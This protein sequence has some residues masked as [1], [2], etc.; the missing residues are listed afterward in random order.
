MVS[1]PVFPYIRIAGAPVRNEVRQKHPELTHHS[2]RIIAM[3][4]SYI[5]LYVIMTGI[6]IPSVAQTEIFKKKTHQAKD[7]IALN[8]RFLEPAGFDSAAP[9]TQKY[10]LVIFLHGLGERGDDNTAQLKNGILFFADSL[11]RAKHPAFIIVPQC[12]MDDY[13]VRLDFSK[14]GLHLQPEPT[15]ALKAVSDVIDA[16]IAAYPVDV[17]RV[18]IT[19]LSMGGFGTWDLISRQPEKFAAAV[20][21]CGGGDYTQCGKFATMPISVFHGAKDPVVPVQLSRVMVATLKHEGGSP[22]YTEYPEGMH[23]VWDT[24]YADRDMVDWMFSQVKKH[25]TAK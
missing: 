21:V 15:A 2:K 16:T 4:L 7:G 24:T 23:N 17:D 5:L 3:K 1:F 11:N 12:P 25:E 10:P 18:Y 19:G 22:L 14:Q 6:L 20:P 9:G 8:Y 13:W